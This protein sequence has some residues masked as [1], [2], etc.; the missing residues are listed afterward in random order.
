MSTPER[1][2]WSSATHERKVEDFY[3]VGA[4]NYGD[5]HDGY[6]NF[7][8]WEGGITDFQLAAE[9]LVRRMGDLLGLDPQ[10]R[11]LDVACGMGTQDVYLMRHFAPASIDGLDVTWKHVEHGRRRAK[12][13]GM[14]E[15][16][17]FHHGTATEIPFPDASFSH[18]LSIEG[19]VHFD[20][21]RK[22]LGE[23]FRVLEPGGVVGITDYSLKREPRTAVERFF[24]GLVCRLWKVPMENAITSKVYEGQ[25]REA[26]FAEIDLKE[27]GA[28]T[29]PGYYREQRRPETIAQNAKIRGFVAGRLGTIIDIV[30][31]RTFRM[32][33]IEYVMARAVKP[34][35]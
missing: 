6:L 23:A 20:T 19:T 21:R 33:L 3:G 4:E 15:R 9:N 25:L 30:L 27:I 24:V 2:V 35:R 16:I 18:L 10:S 11:L 17:R 1:S 13:A 7:G 14:D 29:I 22:F 5:H 34:A 26:G 31:Y 28:L 12:E 32:G 8:L